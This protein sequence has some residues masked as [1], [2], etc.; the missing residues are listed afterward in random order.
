M[1]SISRT[2]KSLHNAKVAILF[3]CIN[4]ILQ[5][6]SRKI[7]LDYLGSE[8]L[9]L[10][11]TAQNLLGFLNIAEL[12]V[13]TAV[14]YTLYRPLYEGDRL[15]INEIVSVQGWLYR[16][17]AAIVIVGAF[18]LMCFFPWIFAKAQVPLWYTYAS[19]IALLVSSLL[20]YYVNFRQ[21]V[22]SAD[23]KEYK[24]TCCLGG[25]RIAKVLLQMIAIAFLSEGYLFWVII[26]ILSAFLIS[27]WLNKEI[28]KEY[29]WLSPIIDK[30]KLLSVEYSHIIRK[31]KQLFCH[32][33]ASFVLS[34]TSPLIIYAYASLTLVAAYGNYMLIV[35]GLC[36]LMNAVLNGIN[37]GIGNLVAEGD[38]RRIKLVFWR[39]TFIRIWIAGIICFTF[40][41]MGNTFV[42][43]WVGADFI[44]PRTAFLILVFNTFIM[45]TRTNDA[46]LAAYGLFQ[47]V[48]SPIVEAVLNLGLS[49]IFGYYWGLTGI[50]SG[51]LVSLVVVVCSWK[52][53][54]LYK[55]GFRDNVSEYAIRYIK[56]LIVL[57]ISSFLCYRF[58][59]SIDI[60]SWCNWIIM[61]L[62]SL[63]TFVF[64]SLIFFCFTDRY[65][66]ASVRWIKDI[67]LAT[68]R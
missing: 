50:L 39:I 15:T 54:F 18:L 38:I 14:S 20:G 51:V 41:T 24:V 65:A 1:E 49:I 17:I 61:S 66:R 53:Y 57:V 2:S 56:Y 16:K 26:E 22:L 13:G 11:T 59:Q 34:Q 58:F 30:G 25:G 32:K 4:L 55:E 40:Y 45:I 5:F 42:A 19:F 67:W 33:I 8:V 21:I 23:Q 27:W 12:G 48:G 62:Y 10:N 35:T 37:A 64:V 3:Y 47:D 28:D 36:A 60:Q 29:P 68:M 44:I 63:F 46:F 31:T 52:P 7:F 43:L 6:F 9:G